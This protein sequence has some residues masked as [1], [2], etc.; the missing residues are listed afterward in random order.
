MSLEE[1]LQLSK[2]TWR[3]FRILSEFVEGF[4]TMHRVG[5]AV[6]V[7]GSARTPET[8]KYYQEDLMFQYHLH[9]LKINCQAN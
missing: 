8:D 3:L 5:P 9:Q 1:D 7:F 6:S 2:E 4:E